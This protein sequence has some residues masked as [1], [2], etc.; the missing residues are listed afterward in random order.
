MKFGKN[1][2]RLYSHFTNTKKRN[3]FVEISVVNKYITMFPMGNSFF[4]K[5]PGMFY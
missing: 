1:G 2:M 4:L 5:F 3:K